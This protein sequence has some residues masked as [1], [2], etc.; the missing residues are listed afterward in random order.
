ML[1]NLSKSLNFLSRLFG[2]ELY[3]R[4]FAVIAYISKPPVRRGTVKKIQCRKAAISKPPV[5]RGTKKLFF[6]FVLIYF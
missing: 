4:I 2:G 3:W 5:R 6:T 1:C